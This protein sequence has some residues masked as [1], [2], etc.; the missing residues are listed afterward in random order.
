[1]SY[2]FWYSF[3]EEINQIYPLETYMEHNEQFL[4]TNMDNYINTVFWQGPTVE[5]INADPRWSIRKANTAKSLI[6]EDWSAIV[7]RVDDYLYGFLPPR[8]RLDTFKGISNLM[9][10]TVTNFYSRQIMT[11]ALFMMIRKHALVT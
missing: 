8:T 10:L 6:N 9:N 3:S 2:S 11:L 7:D 5:Q 4:F 1:M